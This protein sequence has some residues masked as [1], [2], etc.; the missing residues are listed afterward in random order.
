MTNKEIEL[1]FLSI[2]RMI[3]DIKGNH[4]EAIQQLG[5]LIASDSKHLSASDR[6]RLTYALNTLAEI[7]VSQYNYPQNALGATDKARKIDG[8]T[9]FAD[10]DFKIDLDYVIKV[11]HK[12]CSGY[13]DSR[14]HGKSEVQDENHFSLDDVPADRRNEVFR[15]MLKD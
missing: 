2:E 10:D 7:D 15:M 9:L 14:A 12:V 8:F 4:Y 13:V 3:D 1:R 11:Q 6:N 5:E